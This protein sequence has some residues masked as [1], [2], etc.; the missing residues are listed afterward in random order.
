MPSL[1]SQRH[2]QQPQRRYQ[3]RASRR[4]AL[5]KELQVTPRASPRYQT[6]STAH[7]Q[8]P[9]PPCGPAPAAA[10]AA[11]APRKPSEAG[12][13]TRSKLG[14]PTKP[15]SEKPSPEKPSPEKPGPEKPGSGKP[16]SKKPGNRRCGNGGPTRGPPRTAAAVDLTL[17]SPSPLPPVPPEPEPPGFHCPI[18]LREE[19]EGRPPKTIVTNCCSNPPSPSLLPKKLKI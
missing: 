4:N 5:D 16:G 17:A 9:S 18:C 12:G 7:L 15:G 10:A 3:T 1:R 2:K 8:L 19:D 14:K 6:R 11:V 13:K